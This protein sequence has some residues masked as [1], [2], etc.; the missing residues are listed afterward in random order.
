MGQKKGYKQTPEHI[1]KRKKWGAEHHAWKGDDV[2]SRSAHR[3]AE[4]RFE[5]QPCEDCGNTKSERHHEDEDPTNNDP[6]NIKFLCRKCHMK[7]DGRLQKLK[8]MMPEVQ[9]L[10]VEA[11]RQWRKQNG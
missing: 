10:G 8:D 2:G 11:A 3:R 4:L 5:L 7:R 6:S 1:E 9:P